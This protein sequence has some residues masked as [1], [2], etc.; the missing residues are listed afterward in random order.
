M[1]DSP[2]KNAVTYSIRGLPAKD[3]FSLRST[4]RMA[5]KKVAANWD[6]SSS[7]PCDVLFLGATQ[8][9]DELA[10]SSFVPDVDATL[11]V[12]VTQQAGHIGLALLLPVHLVDV[13]SALHLSERQLKAGSSLLTATAHPDTFDPSTSNRLDRTD[14]LPIVVPTGGSGDLGQE[15][16]TGSHIAIDSTEKDLAKP[17]Y[18]PSLA[19]RQPDTTKPIEMLAASESPTYR[20]AMTATVELVRWPDHAYLKSNPQ[21][22]RLATMLTAK[23]MDATTLAARSRASHD[24]CIRFISLMLIAKRARV[25]EPEPVVAA[26]D[27]SPSDSRNTL[28]AA[29]QARLGIFAKIRSRLGAW[30]ASA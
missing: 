29:Q 19:A 30:G 21:Y 14:H 3:E 2:T 12:P 25:I 20:L 8:Q 11:F 4:I 1:A 10:P 22:V 5:E 17:G 6:Y 27:T 24:L 15:H 16:V 9:P 28:T 26:D 13:M 18:N 23:P 7:L